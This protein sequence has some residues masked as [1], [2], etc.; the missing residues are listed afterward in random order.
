MKLMSKKEVMET[1]DVDKNGRIEVDDALELVKHD[2]EKAL[3]YGAAVG[4]AAGFGAMAI[5]CM[6]F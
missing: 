6:V 5:L 4:F 3:M 2:A 1:L